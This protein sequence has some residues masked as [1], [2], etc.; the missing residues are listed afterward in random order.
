[1]PKA[2]T[3][4]LASNHIQSFELIFLHLLYQPHLQVESQPRLSSAQHLWSDLGPSYILLLPALRQQEGKCKGMWGEAEP[5]AELL[6]QQNKLLDFCGSWRRGLKR[7]FDWH[8]LY[9]VLK[10][11]LNLPWLEPFLYFYSSLTSFH[12]PA[13]GW[14]MLACS[15]TIWWHPEPRL[16]ESIY[17]CKNKADMPGNLATKNKISVRAK[18]ER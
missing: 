11:L 12:S 7:Y 4:A 5:L 6:C 3:T 10:H 9:F 18:G 17:V 15:K 13:V 8:C 14:T 1:M 16:G 2:S